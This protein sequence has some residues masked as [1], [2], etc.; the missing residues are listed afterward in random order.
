MGEEPSQH[1]PL[2]WNIK[3]IWWV[4]FNLSICALPPPL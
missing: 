3:S 2:W 1:L 4:C